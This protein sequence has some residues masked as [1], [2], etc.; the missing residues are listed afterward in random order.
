MISNADNANLL[1]KVTNLEI[2]DAVFQ[3][4]PDK[5]PGPDGLPPYWRIV[6]NSVTRVVKAFFIP[7]R[8]LRKTI[9][10]S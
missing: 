6:G 10:L 7:K 9:I 5:A 2:Y 8:F 1:A 4:D 3:L